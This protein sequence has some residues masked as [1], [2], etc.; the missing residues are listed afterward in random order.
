MEGIVQ[1]VDKAEGP[2]LGY[3]PRTRQVGRAKRRGGARGASFRRGV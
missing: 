3:C 1:L 2:V